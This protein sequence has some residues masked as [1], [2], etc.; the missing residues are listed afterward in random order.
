MSAPDPGAV[1]AGAAG[2]SGPSP[3][4]LL[5]ELVDFSWR[6]DVALASS[7]LAHALRPVLNLRVE[8]L[9]GSA[10]TFEA[11]ADGFHALRHAVAAALAEVEALA[12]SKAVAGHAPRR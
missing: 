5:P 7:A 10:A 11:S 3:P 12:A 4:S 8:A 2:A 9:D 1:P 6:T